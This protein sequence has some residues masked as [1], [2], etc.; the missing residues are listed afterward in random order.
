MNIKRNLSVLSEGLDIES[1]TLDTKERGKET[2]G[3][4]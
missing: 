1:T 4:G 3:D 2:L